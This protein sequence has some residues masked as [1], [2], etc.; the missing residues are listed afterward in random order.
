MSHD[1]IKVT[2]K[3]ALQGRISLTGSRESETATL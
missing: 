3:E 1:V 2:V